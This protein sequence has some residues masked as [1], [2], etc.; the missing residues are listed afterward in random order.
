ME[1]VAPTRCRPA[2]AVWSRAWRWVCATLERR[3][4]TQE[5]AAISLHCANE[6]LETHHAWK[7]GSGY[8]AGRLRLHKGRISSEPRNFVDG[9][10]A[11]NK[12]ET[13]LASEPN[14]D[15]QTPLSAMLAQPGRP[16]QRSRR[17]F[18]PSRTP[19]P[20]PLSKKLPD[21]CADAVNNSR[22]SPEY[23][24][25]LD[26]LPAGADPSDFP[27]YAAQ[28]PLHL[29]DFFPL[30]PPLKHQFKK[31]SDGRYKRVGKLYYTVNGSYR[32]FTSLDK[33]YRHWHNNDRLWGEI[34]VCAARAAAQKVVDANFEED[35]NDIG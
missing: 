6:C 35:G 29:A 18:S 19:T 31:G 7:D 15:K 17:R 26:A 11:E 5:R 3:E 1:L 4:E 13:A 32:V 10:V 12:I 8:L 22:T 25:E 23:C 28:S 16:S 21:G 24:L 33:A 34:T 2:A 30:C 27:T 14:I 9:C 20:P